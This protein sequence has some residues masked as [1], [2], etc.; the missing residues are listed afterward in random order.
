M[1]PDVLWTLPLL[2]V[3]VYRAWAK[4]GLTTE[5]VEARPLAGGWWFIAQVMANA[6]L[7]RQTSCKMLCDTCQLQGRR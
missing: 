5:L 7:L 4:E 3:K 1:H 2:P 6:D